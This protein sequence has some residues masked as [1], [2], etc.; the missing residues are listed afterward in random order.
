MSFERFETILVGMIVDQS[1]AAPADVAVRRAWLG[2]QRVFVSS[3]M[4]DTQRERATA[5]KAI[6]DVGAVPAAFEEFGRDADAEEAFLCEVD[7]ATA[8]RGELVPPSGWGSWRIR[9]LNH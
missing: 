7:Q 5:I 4:A 1:P 8:A 6:S 9:G 3:A 2:R